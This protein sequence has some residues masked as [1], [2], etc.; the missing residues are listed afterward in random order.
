MN[1]EQECLDEVMRLETEIE[2]LKNR[3]AELRKMANE[4]AREKYRR[5]A[6]V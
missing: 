6:N 3:Q 5:E 1:N 4:F 2:I